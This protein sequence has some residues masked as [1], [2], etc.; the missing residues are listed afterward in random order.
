MSAGKFTLDSSKVGQ[1]RAEVSK[2]RPECTAKAWAAI[3][4]HCQQRTWLRRTAPGLRLNL[5]DTI[6]LS[7]RIRK[8][9][10]PNDGLVLNHYSKSPDDDSICGRALDIPE[11]HLVGQVL[12]GHTK[13]LTPFLYVSYPLGWRIWVQPAVGRNPVNDDRGVPEHAEEQLVVL[14]GEGLDVRV[15]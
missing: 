13:V 11:A 15:D 9:T 6:A 4:A 3:G 7:E 5:P 10:R 8:G 1:H 2:M 14:C 12:L